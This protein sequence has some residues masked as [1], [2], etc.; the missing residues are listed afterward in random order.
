MMKKLMPRSPLIQFLR[1]LHNRMEAH[2]HADV[3][4][5]QLL[6]R[7]AHCRDED[8]FR[9]LIS[10]HAAMVWNVCRR[11]LTNE[12]DAEDVFQASFM[13][14]A[15]KAGAVG[16][17]ESVGGWLFQ[18]AYRLALKIKS[19]NTRQCTRT[20]SHEALSKV[21]GAAMVPVNDL[22]N[23]IDEELN[24]LPA[25]YR[26]VILLVH[27]QDKTRDQA[28]QALGC[29]P[30][31]VKIRLERA[32][33]L[34][35]TRLARRGLAVGTVAGVSMTNVPVSAA[36]VAATVT[37]AQSF[38]SNIAGNAT[39]TAALAKGAI[40]TMTLTKI[41]LAA[42]AALAL[43]VLVAGTSMAI[44]GRSRPGP[45][46]TPFQKPAMRMMAAALPAEV[47]RLPGVI[48]FAGA[49]TREFQFIHSL[50]QRQAEKKRIDLRI[51]LQN[52]Q[53]PLA[54]S[55]PTF[56]AKKGRGKREDEQGR[57]SLLAYDLIIAI[58]ADWSAFQKE[59]MANLKKWVEAHGGGLIVIGG[60]VNTFQLTR[61]KNEG[62]MKPLLDILPVTLD[63]I[64]IIDMERNMNQPWRL[65]F[66]GVTE[67]DAYL[68]LDT[69]KRALSGWNEFFFGTD[70]SEDT[71]PP[72]RG[73]YD[74]YPVR[75]AKEKAHVVATFSDPQA[76][77]KDGK[78]QPYLVWTDAGKG[79]TFWI[80]S[81]ETWRLRQYRPEYFELFWMQLVQF[82]APGIRE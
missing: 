7:F 40:R 14:L 74:F 57:K 60:P 79:K 46:N 29:K 2:G 38:V 59:D 32:R 63:D 48:L 51:C 42:C 22:R 64:R 31:T 81:G 36:L 15:R 28:A 76:R 8:A 20:N 34:L 82:V 33:T 65:N 11:V 30:G 27:Y 66:S 61:L 78:E 69:D 17:Q 56:L 71:V 54:R 1:N 58:D 41:K 73:F 18:V 16:W 25:S 4:D 35:R 19:R 75:E 10:Q 47:E 68:K 6:E 12:Q 13:V 52:S 72:K 39:T 37:D 67:K 45:F 62:N 43:A 9:R 55:L 80:G 5:R 49:P 53:D 24:G 50:L 23:V 70:S 44:S 3:T 21:E 77:L 26:S